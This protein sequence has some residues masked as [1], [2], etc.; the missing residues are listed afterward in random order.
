MSRAERIAFISPRFPEGATVG[1]AETLLRNLAT[2]AVGAKREVTFLTTCARNHFT[3]ANEIPP[4]E[5]R[6]G[7]LYVRFFPVDQDRDISSFLRIQETISRGGHVAPEDQQIWLANSVNSKPL[8]EYLQTH[9][10]DFDRIVAGPY[11]YG[12]TYFA[13]R[14]MPEKTMLVPCLHDE[15]FAYLEAF[16]E[17]S[18]SVA[19]IMFNS[20]PERDLGCKLYGLDRSRCFV[21]GMGLDPFKVD[22]GA[23]A[24]SRGI[25]SS[26]VIYSGRREPLKGTPMLLDYLEAFKSR[27]GRD[28]KLVVTGS[29][30]LNIPPGLA[31]SVIDAGFLSEQDKHDAMAGAVAFC[32]PSRNESFSIVI[33]ES[34]LAGTPVLVTARSEVMRHHCK[35]SNGG[36]WFRT[37]PEFEEELLAILDNDELRSAMG[38]SGHDYVTAEY[39]WA[40]IEE[41][42]FKALDAD[43]P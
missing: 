12:I 20:E 21:V 11:L 29:G 17:M 5:K 32:H 18:R 33:L 34:W 9:G 7:N 28:V 10:A 38:R 43:L 4:G 31:G 27:T 25:G 39:S 42:L 41:R 8:Y 16:G 22:P 30:Q 40:R 37:Y 15:S 24:R 6:F 26:Y 1:G 36:L 23:F 14:I 35:V 19:G 2:R 13:S 3:W